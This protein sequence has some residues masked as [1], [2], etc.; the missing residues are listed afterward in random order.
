MDERVLDVLRRV[1]DGIYVYPEDQLVD[2]GCECALCHR[3]G[4]QHY[5]DCLTLV[6]EQVLLDLGFR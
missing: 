6:A 1:A 3:G 2:R 5:D 4:Y